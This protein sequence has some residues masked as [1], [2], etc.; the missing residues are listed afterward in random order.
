VLQPMPN[1]KNYAVSR[2]IHHSTAAVFKPVGQPNSPRGS[3]IDFKKSVKLG[4][5]KKIKIFSP[6][7]NWNLAFHSIMNEGNKVIYGLQKCWLTSI[8][9]IIFIIWV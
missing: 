9:L 7:S 8:N 6:N 4:W 1:A 3:Y 5:G 2:P